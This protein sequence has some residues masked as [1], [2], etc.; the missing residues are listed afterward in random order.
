MIKFH[1]YSLDNIVMLQCNV[2][3]ALVCKTPLVLTPSGSQLVFG[4][5]E[6]QPR[7]GVEGRRGDA[8]LAAEAPVNYGRAS[9]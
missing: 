6:G 2:F 1:G 5:S 3:A 4:A 7:Q 9:Y 8:R